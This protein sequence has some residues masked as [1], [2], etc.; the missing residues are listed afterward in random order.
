MRP[1]RIAAVVGLCWAIVASFLLLEQHQSLTALR[2][3]VLN[4]RAQ[5]KELS[6]Q[7][8]LLSNRLNGIVGVASHSEDPPREVLRLRGEI[9]VVR[10]LLSEVQQSARENKAG[11]SENSSPE[12]VQQLISRGQAACMRLKNLCEQLRDKE[13]NTD[14]DAFVQQ[15][16]AVVPDSVLI[17]LQEQRMQA[18]Q[19]LT[20][21]GLQPDKREGLNEAVN[22]ISKKISD[23]TNGI[24]RG[25]DVQQAA[26]NE[27][28]DGMDKMA[29]DERI[30]LV[31]KIE[32]F[33]QDIESKTG[34]SL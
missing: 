30:R 17:S 22:E 23:R 6:E 3:E 26:L 14:P 7:A 32:Q 13:A 5:N 4:Q 18:V 8:L 34:Q 16:L 29:G 24:L 25:L 11:S 1:I 10:R 21:P 19:A 20:E 12:N 31:N 27:L 15:I 33:A 28:L 9:A 2:L